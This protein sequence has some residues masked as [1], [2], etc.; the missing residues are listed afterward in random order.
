MEQGAVTAANGASNE[1]AGDVMVIAYVPCTGSKPACLIAAARC[2]CQDVEATATGSLQARAAL[3]E[4]H[5]AGLAHVAHATPREPGSPCMTRAAQLAACGEGADPLG[6]LIQQLHDV[7]H[8]SAVGCKQWTAALS[9]TAGGSTVTADAASPAPARGPQVHAVFRL[10][11]D[12]RPATES[13]DKQRA[14]YKRRWW[15]WRQDLDGKLG[16]VVH[17]LDT[18]CRGA[19]GHCLAGVAEEADNGEEECAEAPPLALLL[20]GGL[21]CLPWEAVPAL[22]GVAI[23]RALHLVAPLGLPHEHTRTLRATVEATAPP[24]VDVTRALY[25]VDP[26]GDLPSTRQRFAEWFDAVPGWTGSSG[27]PGLDASQLRQELI[28]RELFVYLGHGAGAILQETNR[29]PSAALAMPTAC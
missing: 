13:T 12:E 1:P 19:L 8:E 16:G 22:R 29:Y 4:L 10:Q 6:H 27:P 26:A 18:L 2:L 3:L 11:G 17:D 9:D 25:V 7:T 28:A 5:D 23:F 21:H 20:A 14:A 15:E 24:G